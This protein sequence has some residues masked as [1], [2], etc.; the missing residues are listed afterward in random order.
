MKHALRPRYLAALLLAAA[1]ALQLAVAE[2]A[3]RQAAAARVASLASRAQADELQSRIAAIESGLA[4]RARVARIDVSGATAADDD[5]SRL[6]RSLLSALEGARVSGTELAVTSAPPPLAT[7]AR[8]R[9][10]GSFLDV[11]RLSSRLVR[12]GGGLILRH[13][14]MASAR[15]GAVVL[16]VE[17][18]GMSA[19]QK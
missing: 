19:R 6:R 8:I 12:P 11:V 18:V 2:P 10:E 14:R 16:E 9:A 15:D 7:A 1:G 17:G 4:L 3:R 5:L 13:V